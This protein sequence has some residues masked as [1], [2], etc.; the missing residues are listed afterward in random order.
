MNKGFYKTFLLLIVFYSFSVFGAQGAE[1]ELAGNIARVAHGLF[2]GCPIA[3]DEMQD[4]FKEIKTINS[5]NNSRRNSETSRDSNQSTASHDTLLSDDSHEA[6][7]DMEQIMDTCFADPDKTP[8]KQKE[9]KKFIDML[10]SLEN[11]VTP[12]IMTKAIVMISEKLFA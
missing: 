3:T 10:H 9:R 6:I 4:I 7:D 5:K 2:A 1:H 12:D 8:A 11:T